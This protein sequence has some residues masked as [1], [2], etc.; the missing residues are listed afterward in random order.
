MA[1]T[2]ISLTSLEELVKSGA[3]QK[4]AEN[5]SE[6]LTKH[7]TSILNPAIIKAGNEITKALM[8]VLRDKF[9]E[10]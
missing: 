4:I 6:E 9:K 3:T 10:G 2:A 7:F 1:K 5:V 8:E